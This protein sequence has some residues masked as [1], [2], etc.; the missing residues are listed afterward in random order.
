MHCCWRTF[1]FGIKTLLM[2]LPKI[3]PNSLIGKHQRQCSSK[4][5]KLSIGQ[6]CQIWLVW[7]AVHQYQLVSFCSLIN[8]WLGNLLTKF[9]RAHHYNPNF[10]SNPCTSI[11]ALLF[12]IIY[13]TRISLIEEWLIV[14]LTTFHDWPLGT[15][16]WCTVYPQYHLNH[17]ELLLLWQH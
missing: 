13:I 2:L 3:A 8:R 14:R 15:I 16:L 17:Q 4:I 5:M 6:G 1:L 7:Q 9:S 10:H 11:F 12:S